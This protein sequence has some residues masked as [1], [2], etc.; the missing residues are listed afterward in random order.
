MIRIGAKL[1]GGWLTQ[2][3]TRRAGTGGTTKVRVALPSGC[4]G[5]EDQPQV[6]PL[7]YAPVGMT[8]F[9]WAL[10]SPTEI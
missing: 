10:A 1:N 6:P 7:R 8:N 9:S 4:D 3:K 2:A 5:T